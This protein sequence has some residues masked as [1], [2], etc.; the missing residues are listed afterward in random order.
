MMGACV[1]LDTK[2]TEYDSALWIWAELWTITNNQLKCLPDTYNQ[3]TITSCI[4]DFLQEVE[5]LDK[6]YPALDIYSNKK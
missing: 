2:S 5:T 3:N 6:M 4:V 1:Q